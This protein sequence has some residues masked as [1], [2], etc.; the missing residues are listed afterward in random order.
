M[1]YAM[2]FLLMSLYLYTPEKAL[3]FEF[4]HHDTFSNITE[5]SE[6]F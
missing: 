5:K 4:L 3:Q 6:V 1:T 2:Q